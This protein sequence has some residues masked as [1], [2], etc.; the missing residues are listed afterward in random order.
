MG[1]VKGHQ[2]EKLQAGVICKI[3]SK[4]SRYVYPCC[5]QDVLHQ[6]VLS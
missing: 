3:T 2:K 4:A 1:W 6:N 5:N